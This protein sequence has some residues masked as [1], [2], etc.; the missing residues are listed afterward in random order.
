MSQRNRFADVALGLVIGLGLAL[1]LVA[2]T[3]PEFRYPAQGQ[4][5]EQASDQQE[6][7]RPNEEQPN[8]YWVGW[9]YGYVF[10]EDSLPQWI[11]AA[12]TIVAT[13][14][15]VAAFI[16]ARKAVRTNE[17]QVR[18]YFRISDITFEWEPVPFNAGFKVFTKWENCGNSPA[19]KCVFL[20]DFLIVDTDSPEGVQP[21][22][23]KWDMGGAMFSTASVGQRVNLEVCT[24][25]GDDAAKLNAGKTKLILYSAVQYTD[26]FRR[27]FVD[28]VCNVADF[29]DKDGADETVRFRTYPHHNSYREIG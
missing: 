4:S 23:A 29:P 6:G 21:E 10:K 24:V 7:N 9:L 11:M 22:F 8:H 2:W 1:L 19:L 14:F 28:E 18:A 27:A 15:S 20:R 16:W 12:F 3:V 13:G 17:S 25:S 26:V 5:V